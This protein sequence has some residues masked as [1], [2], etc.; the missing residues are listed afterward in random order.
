MIDILATLVSPTFGLQALSGLLGLT[1]PAAQALLL[2][3]FGLR[4][5]WIGTTRALPGADLAILTGEAGSLVVQATVL[6]WLLAS[7]TSLSALVL[8]EGPRVAGLVVGASASPEQLAVKMV[9]LVARF[10]DA[11]LFGALDWITSAQVQ[12]PAVGSGGFGE[13]GS[14]TAPPSSGELVGAVVAAFSVVL[15]QV[16]AAA[17]VVMI[18]LPKLLVVICLA[19]GPFAVAA[20]LGDSQL[21][22]EFVEGW[23]ETTASAML[24]LPVMAVLVVFISNAPLPDASMASEIGAAVPATDVIEAF[25]NDLALLLLVAQLLFMVLP[26][27]SGLVQGRTPSAS[28]FL[29]LILAVCLLPLRSIR[30]LTSLRSSR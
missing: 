8:E 29:G 7:W 23:A 24:A 1:V 18:A 27:A 16:V 3:T 4:L 10:D 9:A 11:A 22:R 5:A 30:L 17:I 13:E 6:L 15:T 2:A 26:I 25:A 14:V 12:P 19:V 28:S 20:Y 21:A